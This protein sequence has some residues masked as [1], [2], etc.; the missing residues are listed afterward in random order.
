MKKVING[1]ICAILSVLTVLFAAA[2][3]KE[4]VYNADRN[5]LFGV[6]NLTATMDAD[7]I[8]SEVTNDWSADMIGALGA[9]STRIWMFMARLINT[10]SSS[11]EVSIRK[12]KCVAVHDYITKLKNNGVERIV[13]MLNMYISPYEFNSSS[14]VVCPSVYDDYDMYVKFL[15][16]MEK[17]FSLIAAEFPEI[18]Y[19]EIE[20]EPDIA[21]G[22]WFHKRNGDSF[23][24]AEG[25][26]ITA[27]LCWYASRAI[28]K[29][30]PE[31]KI[32]LAGLTDGE[33]S[34]KYLDSIYES[35][36]SGYLPTAEEFSDK[37]PDNYFDILAWHPYPSLNDVEGFLKQENAMYDVVK[38][39]GDDGKTV[40]YTEFGFS[41]F[42][43][44]GVS[45]ENGSDDTQQRVA[46]S[47]ILYLDAIKKNLPF[48]ETVFVF[49]LT[50]IKQMYTSGSIENSFGL[51]YSPNDTDD[52]ASVPKPIAL[53]LFK[54]FNGE[55]ADV[56]ALYKYVKNK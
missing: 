2:C 34:P 40:F 8:D 16:K 18:Q 43:F 56:S 42:R 24:V 12:E 27:D 44:G 5:Y 28:K 7:Q 4:K 14:S 9:K 54:Y 41:D 36:E 51:F 39:H 53:A 3:E 26:H 17:C 10:S 46:D 20:N 37:N 6:C 11:D 1:V 15:A 22:S 19:W 52:K 32:V 13:G 38:A 23:T 25:S 21:H 49:R 45:G 50:N 33:N 55:N 29:V 35:I 48:V 31:N 30:N 47:M